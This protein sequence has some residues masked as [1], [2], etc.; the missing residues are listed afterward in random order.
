MKIKTI[1]Q[2]IPSD[3]NSR[4]QMFRILVS[5]LGVLC[6]CYVYLIGSITFNVLARKTLE[7]NARV[8]S[9]NV[10]QLELQYIALS[11]SINTSYGHNLG[12]VEASGTIFASRDKATVAMK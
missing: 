8:V 11:N 10:S 1:T 3:D 12:Y 7:A 6:M 9:G 4:K 5:T 2:Q